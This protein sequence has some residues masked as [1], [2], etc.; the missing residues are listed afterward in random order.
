MT[1]YNRFI[2]AL[3]IFILPSCT[4]NHGNFTVLSN[5]IVDTQ[6]FNLGQSTRKRKVQG[7]DISHTIIFF[8]TKIPKLSEAL[9]NAFEKSDTDLM[10][11][12]NISRTWWYIPYIYG[13]EAWIVTG[14]A[15]KTREN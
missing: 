13:Q 11:D 12:V 10:T 14:D 1:K 4:F 5:K 8:P 9:N 6:H 7:K 15:I 2:F 3:F